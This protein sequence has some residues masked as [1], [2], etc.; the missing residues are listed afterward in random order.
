M[1]WYSQEARSYMLFAAFSALSFLFFARLDRRRS[2]RDLVAWTVFSALALATHFFAGFLVAPE[3]LWLLWRLRDRRTV[4]AVVGVALVQVALVPLAVSDSTHSVGWIKAFPLSVRI[5]QVPVEFALSTLYKSGAVSYG[6]IGAAVLVLA[7][8]ALLIWGLPGERRRGALLA[9]GVAAFAILVP[10]AM[11]ALGRDYLVPRNLIAAWVPLALVLAAACTAPRTLPA[12]VA[13]A[14]L[15]VA[16][17]LYS[18]ALIDSRWQYQRDDWRGVARALGPAGVPRA[19]VAYDSGFAFQPLAIYLRGVS[20]S[21]PTD[22]VAVREVDV[23]GNSWQD[24]PPT[25]PAG[26]RLLSE[27][28]VAGFRVLRFAITGAWRQ[29]PRELGARAGALLPPAPASPDV[30][31]QRPA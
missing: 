5:K 16:S 12:G 13:L 17:F 28:T 10:I 9:A 26:V 21:V 31:I 23:I 22:A 4:A 11:A 2:N 24:A 3:A 29:T 8:A 18:G 7:V 6:L 27:R 30:L 20:W 15:L 25:L 19:I 1:I 14:S